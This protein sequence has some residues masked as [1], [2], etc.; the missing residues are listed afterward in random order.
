[1]DTVEI[2]EVMDIGQKGR[3]SESHNRILIASAVRRALERADSISESRARITTC[4]VCQRLSV[5][6]T[7]EVGCQAQPVPVLDFQKKH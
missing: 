6:R 7:G 4:G 3:H 5:C 2:F 1:M